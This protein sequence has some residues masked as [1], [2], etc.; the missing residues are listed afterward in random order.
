MQTWQKVHY[1][2]AAYAKMQITG[3]TAGIRQDIETSLVAVNE[4]LARYPI[5]TFADYQKIALPDLLQMHTIVEKLSLRILER[6]TNERT[7]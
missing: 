5:K 1:A 7:R 4:I 3:L 6:G 2:L